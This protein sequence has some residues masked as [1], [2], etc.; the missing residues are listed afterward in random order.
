MRK[1]GL[2]LSPEIIYFYPKTAQLNCYLAEKKIQQKPVAGSRHRAILDLKGRC[3]FLAME[4]IN[5]W[6]D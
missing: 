6:N 4:V 5:H 2:F 3:K 1:S